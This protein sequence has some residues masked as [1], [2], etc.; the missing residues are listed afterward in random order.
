MLSGNI[1]I[2]IFE[3][4]HACCHALKCRLSVRPHLLDLLRVG[5]LGLVCCTATWLLT[6]PF[7]RNTIRET[8]GGEYSEA[9]GRILP[10]VQAAG[11][12]YRHLTG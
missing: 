3:L 2:R 5:K 6:R 1:Y 12:R 10:D 9:H 8:L 4:E 7:H 11:G